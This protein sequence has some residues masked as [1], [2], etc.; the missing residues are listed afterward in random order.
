MK[1]YKVLMLPEDQEWWFRGTVRL[2]HYLFCRL[3]L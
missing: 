3:A 2:F 1:D